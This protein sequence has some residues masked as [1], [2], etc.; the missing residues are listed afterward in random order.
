M[1]CAALVC[2]WPSKKLGHCIHPRAPEIPIPSVT[3]RMI[4][5]ELY[6][7]DCRQAGS[8]TMNH[9]AVPQVTPAKMQPFMAPK[10]EQP[11]TAHVIAPNAANSSVGR[12]R[13]WV[14]SP[15]WHLLI[16]I[17]LWVVPC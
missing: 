8:R 2:S 11:R 7:R 10:P 4:H 9:H 5:P 3:A 14:K 17:A 1:P 16:A 13:S 6:G 15:R 12:I